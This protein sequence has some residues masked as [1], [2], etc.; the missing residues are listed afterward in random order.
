MMNGMQILVNLP[1]FNVEMPGTTMIIIEFLV[2]VAGFDFPYVHA[3]DIFPDLPMG[4][5]ELNFDK[6]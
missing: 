3:R 4:D 5:D 2:S 6:E 1:A